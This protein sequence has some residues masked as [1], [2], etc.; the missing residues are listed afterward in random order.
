MKRLTQMS[1]RGQ[2][3]FFV[4]CAAIAFGFLLVGTKSSPLYPINDWVDV[5]CFMTVGRSMLS[6]LVPYRDLMEQKGPFLYALFALAALMDRAGYLGVFLLEWCAMTVFCF[7]GGKTAAL[8]APGPGI[9]V[10]PPLL[11]AVVV[12][13]AAFTHGGSAEE[14]ALPLLAISLY[15]F[16]RALFF[17]QAL[18]YRRVAL[19]GALA[20]AILWMKY[21]VLGF[22]FAWMACLFFALLGRGE[23]RR[24]F[25][26]CLAFLGGM[27][28]FSL[29]ILLYF[30]ANGALKHLFSVYF[31]DNIFRY[32]PAYAPA[33][34]FGRYWLIWRE[35]ARRMPALVGLGALGY[36][37]LLLRRDLPWQG[38]AAY[39]ALVIFL[40]ATV[41]GAG[42]LYIY[43]PLVLG[44]FLIP[45]AALAAGVLSR[46]R[47]R[48]GT[49][50]AVGG[51]T[52]ALALTLIPFGNNNA[53]AAWRREDLVQTRFAAQMRAALP[54]PT[55][56][57]YGFLDGG[58]Y[59]AAGAVPSCR[60][61]CTLNLPL[62]EAEEQQHAMMAAGAFDFVV[63]RDALLPEDYPYVLASQ[64]IQEQE[65]FSFTYRL[66]QNRS[67]G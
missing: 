59:L 53:M 15:D 65:G 19:N 24:G 62:P 55:L 40:T 23:L 14:L 2:A 4:F 25:C 45:C 32:A 13:S 5:N 42:T 22:H 64:Q 26:S 50:L 28:L 12:E 31:Y 1:R 33:Q 66:Y 8:L 56:L 21:T 34:R 38:K 47:R 57:N 54:Q 37:A 35:V 7:Y 60:Y 41:W 52:A 48:A 36:G 46:L 63:T 20:A 67:L 3:L 10:A 44:V 30:G 39:P 9:W 43:Y 18:S 6:G 51:V 11:C 61:F 17:E 29:P 16:V 58:F 49:A 27:A